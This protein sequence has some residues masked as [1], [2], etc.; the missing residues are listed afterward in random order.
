MLKRASGVAA[1]AA[2]PRGLMWALMAVVAVAVPAA[3]WAS[4]ATVPL[5]VWLSLNGAVLLIL[6]N[7]QDRP[8]G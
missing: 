7:R 8:Y 1:R 5:I 4:F 3:L 2:G 6:G